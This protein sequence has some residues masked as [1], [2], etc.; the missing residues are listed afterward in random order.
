M[1]K[2]ACHAHAA[3]GALTFEEACLVKEKLTGG[4]FVPN[5]KAQI[6]RK[7]PASACCSIQNCKDLFGLGR[8]ED[9]LTATFEA[10]TD[11]NRNNLLFGS[12]GIVLQTLER[13]LERYAR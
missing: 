12:S 10:G 5:Q 13:P 8:D 4:S 11:E 2:S 6:F 7:V 9:A 3:K 1:L